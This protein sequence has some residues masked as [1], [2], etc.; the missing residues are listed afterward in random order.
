MSDTSNQPPADR[1]PTSPWSPP[2]GDGSAVPPG[3]PGPVPP[4][5]PAQPGQPVPPGQ[6][7]Q[8]QYGQYA[9]GGYGQQQPANPYGQGQP[10]Y[11]PGYPPQ[12]YQQQYQQGYGGYPQPGQP[13]YGAAGYPGGYRPLPRGLAIGALIV[14]ILSVLAVC[15]PFVSPVLG[16]V[17]IV[18]GVLALSRIRTG[19]AGGRGMA[20]GGVITGVAGL[21]MGLLVVVTLAPLVDDFRVCLQQ[22]TQSQQQQCFDDL[23]RRV[24]DGRLTR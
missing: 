8:P 14:G 20:I 9:P 3:A 4:G 15:L 24:Q 10:G 22:P 19:R 11:P 16:V 6:P 18:L 13:G 1:D 2:R 17:A 5:Q 23:Q 7:G 12:D 21:A